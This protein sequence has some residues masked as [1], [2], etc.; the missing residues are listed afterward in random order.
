M[1]EYRQLGSSGLRVSCLALGTASFGAGGDTSLGPKKAARRQIDIA[2]DAG[3]NLIDTADAYAQGASE[4]TIGDALHGKRER[5][6]IATKARFATGTGPNDGGL[7]RHHLIEACEASL[8]RLRTSYI[9]LYLLHEWDGMTPIDETLAA[10]DDLRRAGKIRYV[11]CSNFSGWQMMKALGIADRMRLP[12][13]VCN[14]IHLSPIERSAE[15]E[16]VPVAVDQDLGLIVWSPLGGGLLSG[17][18]GRDKPIPTDS[19]HA[20]GV[21]EPPIYDWERLYRIIDVINE[22]SAASGVSSPQV[23]IAWLLGRPGV[24]SVILGA[25]N[26]DQLVE[27]LR[28]SDVALNDEDVALLEAASRPPLVYPY[29]HQA[30][31]AR[32][33]LGTWRRRD[34]AL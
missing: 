14:E 30:A 7:S 10:L 33:R 27:S 3:I 32:D 25:R 19:R 12:R 13:F 4:L 18:V 5:M 23:V 24:T 1:M 28:S 9:D 15:Y 16:I 22:I 29:W 31:H 34:V 11:G 20:N 6:L 17:R 2:L 21:L 8:T 26:D